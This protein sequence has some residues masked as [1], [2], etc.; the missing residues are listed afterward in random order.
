MRKR[1]LIW[2]GIA[3]ILYLFRVPIFHIPLQSV[4]LNLG[5]AEHAPTLDQTIQAPRHW[6]LPSELDFR[7]GYISEGYTV[8]SGNYPKILDD[9]YNSHTFIIRK[10]ESGCHPNCDLE[11]LLDLEITRFIKDWQVTRYTHEELILKN[12]RSCNLAVKNI[13]YDGTEYPLRFI[14]EG[15]AFA[16]ACDENTYTGQL[17]YSHHA[18]RSVGSQLVA[19]T[20]S[21]LGY[22]RFTSRLLEEVVE[23]FE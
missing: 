15:P 11:E 14:F 6:K 18:V 3:L 20:G 4:L 23:K 7:G 1:V 19:R 22:E 17:F 2:G 21:T 8:L 16:I 9:E 10:D 13:L 5:R 12:H